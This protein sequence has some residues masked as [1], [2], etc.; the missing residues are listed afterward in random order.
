LAADWYAKSLRQVFKTNVLGPEF[1]PI[2]R[3]RNLFNKN[4]LIKIPQNQSLS[5]TKESIMKIDNSFN[6]I[7]DFRSVR[8]VLNVDNY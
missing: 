8:V 6:A 2:S 5:K 4:I 3:I 1:P 7:K